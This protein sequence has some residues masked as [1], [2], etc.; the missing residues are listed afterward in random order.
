M[1]SVDGK[2]LY[3]CM[4]VLSGKEEFSANSNYLEKLNAYLL[5]DAGCISVTF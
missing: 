4:C 1:K 3:N 5:E 2:V